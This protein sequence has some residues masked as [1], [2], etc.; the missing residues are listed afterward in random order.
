MKK[1]FVLLA[2]ICTLLGTSAM[3]FEVAPVIGFNSS[4]L[5]VTG[6]TGDDAAAVYSSKLGMDYGVLASFSMA[7]LVSLQ[8]GALMDKRKY[9]VKETIEGFGIGEAEVTMNYI[10]IPVLLRLSVFPGLSV[11]A[12]GYYATG[13][14]DIHFKATETPTGGTPA[15]TETDRAWPTT[16]KKSDNPALPGETDKWRSIQVLAGLN[17]GF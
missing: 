5:N 16:T 3:A 6:A 13:T 17:I 8:F 7:P 11:G 12:G 9:G 10:Q 1:T 14:G 15:T 4:T 2:L